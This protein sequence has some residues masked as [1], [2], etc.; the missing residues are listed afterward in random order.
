MTRDPGA[1][2]ASLVRQF[3]D[4][5]M[6]FAAFHRQFIDRYTRLNDRY[7][8]TPAGMEWRRVFGEVCIALPDPVPEEARQAGAIGEAALRG[9][10][11]GQQAQK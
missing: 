3:V 9:L 5:G 11:V 8:A 6:E 2:L 4:Q 10:L 7:L 1:E